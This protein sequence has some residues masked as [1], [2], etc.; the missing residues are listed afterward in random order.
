MAVALIVLTILNWWVLW[1]IALAGILAMIGFDSINIVQLASDYAVSKRTRFALSRFI[2]PMV[3]IV[4]GAFLL[5]IRFDLSSVKSQFPVE[6]T[7]SHGMSYNM[8]KEVLGQNFFLG[9]GP[10]NFS[11]AFDRFGAGELANSPL[12]NIRFFDAASQFATYLVTG[13]A[14]MALALAVLVWGMIQTIVRLGGALTTRKGAKDGGSEATEASGVLS[15]MIAMTV[16]LFLY[17]FNT[18]L[19]AVWFFLMALGALVVSGDRSID[20]DIEQRPAFSL[21]AS[22]GFIIGL[23]LVLTAMYFTFV[24]YLGDVAYARAL[25][26]DSPSAAL[27][28]MAE[29][30][31]LS[32]ANDRYYRD[33]SQITLAQ[34]RNELSIED[35]SNA[36]RPVR[37][38]NL[39]SSAVQLA[40]RA[41]ELE[42]HEALNWSN[43]ASVYRS[44]TGLVDSVEE[45]AEEAYARAAELRPGDPSYDSSVGSMWL[46][47]ADLILRV[48]VNATGE[49]QERL[50][51][52]YEQALER[53]EAAFTR[54]LEQSPS[55]GPAIYNRAAVYD[56]QGRVPEAIEAIE[57]IIPANANNPTLMFEL[58]ILYLRDGRNNDAQAA[59]R[60]AV[61]LS[62]SYANARWYLALL[63]ENQGA[64]EAALEHLRRIEE[65]N[66]GNEILLAKIVQ[67]EQGETAPSAE[68]VADQEPLQDVVDGEPEQE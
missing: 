35:E 12:S 25:R 26:S 44:L 28:H 36:E 29:A 65:N 64:I 14:L 5:L 19:L 55:L 52:Q 10:E 37:I 6:I 61:L 39:I 57:T 31:S 59:M 11:L 48:A 38:Q 9:Y 40:R 30:V 21:A 43:L 13:G 58:G 15:A 47:R 32:D 49:N 62:P 4:L 56:R 18:V 63:L 8:I 1:A 41:T 23:I 67:L 42:P 60:R 27:E 24:R 54:A 16:A 7:P 20:I 33:A 45:L 2:V 51:E 3:V 17:P 22:L 46:T 50:G 34:L 53:A 68:E 66:P